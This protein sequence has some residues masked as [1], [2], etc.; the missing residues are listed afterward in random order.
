MVDH[1]FDEQR[2][3]REGRRFIKI[4]GIVTVI[5]SSSEGDWN[6]M[7]YDLVSTFVTPYCVIKKPALIT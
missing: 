5:I 1:E 4:M 2:R 3:S 7:A 6:V